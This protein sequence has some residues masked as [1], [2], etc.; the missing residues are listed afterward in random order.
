MRQRNISHR[1]T[2]FFSE[3]SAEATSCTA[4]VLSPEDWPGCYSEAAAFSVSS[5]YKSLLL[6]LGSGLSCDMITGY[7]LFYGDWLLQAGA[8]KI[9]QTRLEPR[10]NGATWM[11]RHQSNRIPD[12]RRACQ[13]CIVLWMSAG[14]FCCGGG[15]CG[16]WGCWWRRCKGRCGA[17]WWRC[18]CS[19]FWAWHWNKRGVCPDLRYGILKK[20]TESNPEISGLFFGIWNRLLL[21]TSRDRRLVLRREAL[22]RDFWGV[23]WCG[24]YRDARGVK[25]RLTGEIKNR[26]CGMIPE[27]YFSIWNCGRF[28]ALH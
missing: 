20:A 24:M 6:S 9:V 7:C 14:T 11:V 22:K 17:C 15:Q 1:I 16:L 13:H 8:C 19:L 2:A 28:H 26:N 4:N 27:K 10:L 12:T 21:P 5:A 25:G 3:C 18:M 23:Y